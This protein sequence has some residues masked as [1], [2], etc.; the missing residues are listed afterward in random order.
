MRVHA[1][2]SG[3]RQLEQLGIAIL[4]NGIKILHMSSLAFE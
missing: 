2:L 3:P 4:Q 1:E